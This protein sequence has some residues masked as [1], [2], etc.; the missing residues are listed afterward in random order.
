MAAT[1][2]AAVTCAS[3]CGSDAPKAA[4]PVAAV[5]LAGH[6]YQV[7][8]P[9][10]PAAPGALIAATDHGPAPLFD[11]ARRW[12][13]L[14]HS[15]DAHGTDIPVSGTVLLPAGPAPE[16]GLPV[17]S[18]AHGTTGVADQC[19]PSQA[20]DL[21]S[22][23][24]ARQ[25]RRLLRAG[26][27]VAASDYPGLGTP[28]MHTY[29]VGADEG[30]AVVDIVTAA[31]RLV[32][33]LSPV[34]FA[35]GHSQGGQ[36]ALF[37]A[38]AARRAPELRFAGGVA[39]APASHLGA[40]LP[41]VIAAHESSALSFVLYSLA[42]LGAT[43]PSV[44]VRRLVGPSAAGTAQEVLGTCLK[45]GYPALARV[46]T[47]QMLPL[48]PAQITELGGKLSA[49]GDPDRTAIQDPVLVVQGGQDHD[50]PAQWTAE[51]V[52]RLRAL[53]SP[54]ITD[55]AYPGSDHDQVLGRSVCDV[56]AFLAAHGGRAVPGCTP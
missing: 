23:V 8:R 39:I 5:R 27:A 41:G 26:Y 16:G 11:G 44:D 34:W 52:G 46:T 3:G 29:L 32:P 14:Y 49:H 15:V 22:A 7:P 25:V 45:A 1:V 21:G 12:T 47:E 19:A 33:G 9:L 6:T 10:P 2:L 35:M 30:N 40:M 42:G 20:A 31:H 13:V 51:V 17:V 28:G 36:A 43:D 24:Y 56:L 50:V 18:W 4:G 38:N 37:A 53:G 55:R 48:G 54:A